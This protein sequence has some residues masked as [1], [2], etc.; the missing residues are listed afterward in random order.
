MLRAWKGNIWTNYYYTL[1]GDFWQRAYR[2][3]KQTSTQSLC[4]LTARR[5]APADFSLRVIIHHPSIILLLM[6]SSVWSLRPAFGDGREKNTHTTG[7]RLVTF[8]WWKFE[9]F[10]I[11]RITCNKIV[12]N[13][14]LSDT[15]INSSV[16]CKTSLFED[17]LSLKKFRPQD[18]IACVVNNWSKLGSPCH[19]GFRASSLNKGK[20]SMCCFFL[21]TD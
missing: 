14:V 12:I 6:S 19:T 13:L 7:R 21:F 10:M 16:I 3:T 17:V 11:R 18:V 20:Y 8:K 4:R 5:P 1:K 9:S 2:S 15:I